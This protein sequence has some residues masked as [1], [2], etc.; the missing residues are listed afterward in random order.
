M[1]NWSSWSGLGAGSLCTTPFGMLGAG[2]LYST[3]S[4]VESVALDVSSFSE[5][6]LEVVGAFLSRLDLFLLGI[7]GAAS[8]LEL[9]EELG[10]GGVLRA[11]LLEWTFMETF[12]VLPARSLTLGLL[13]LALE[14]LLSRAVSSSLWI[15]SISS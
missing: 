15:C 4:S 12:F 1:G 8:S 5:P 6:A 3:L 9:E 10:L 14:L 11:V 7:R 13:F 2:L